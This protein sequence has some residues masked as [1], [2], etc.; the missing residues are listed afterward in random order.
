MAFIQGLPP[1][2][3]YRVLELLEPYR[4]PYH[5]IISPIAALA[6]ASLV[7]RSWTAPAQEL[8]YRDIIVRSA[9]NVKLVELLQRLPTGPMIQRLKMTSLRLEALATLVSVCEAAS[10]LESLAIQEQD[11]WDDPEL[12]V[13]LL[14][15]KV[16]VGEW[17]SISPSNH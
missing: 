2:L 1:E 12:D 9:P 11:V 17:I 13:E 7:A 5:W 15:P 8:M 3:L 4:D 10:G 6:Q 14:Y 16:L